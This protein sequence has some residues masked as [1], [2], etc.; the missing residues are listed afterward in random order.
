LSGAN[1]STTHHRPRG[2]DD[3]ISARRALRS[4]VTGPSDSSGGLG[5]SLTIN[6]IENSTYAVIEDSNVDVDGALEVAA[7]SESVINS[8]GFGIGVAVAISGNAAAVSATATGA[9]SF[10]E[11]GNVVEAAIRNSATNGTHTINAGSVSVTASDESRIEAIAIAA[12]ASVSGTTSAAG[13]A[14]SIGLALGTR[15]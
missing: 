4:A 13:V 6:D 11:I 12:S 7:F 15:W 2:V 14:V 8:L 10:N 1:A 9:L 5:F 3:W